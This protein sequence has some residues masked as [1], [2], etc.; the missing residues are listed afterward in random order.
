M[1]TKQKNY[2]LTLGIIIIF[3]ASLYG[4]DYFLIQT[5]K[6]ASRA[7]DTASQALANL[8]EKKSLLQNQE[9]DLKNREGHLALLDSVLIAKKE[10]EQV[11]SFKKIEE[12]ADQSG[13]MMDTPSILGVSKPA[14]GAERERSSDK[15]A[16][17]QDEE[18]LVL[19]MQVTGNFANILSFLNGLT[20]LP[21]YMNLEKIQLTKT[22]PQSGGIRGVLQ[23]RIFT[24]N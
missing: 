2:I 1:S 5:I 20:S 23:I 6:E 24:S 11:E 22:A 21:F 15:P 13:V 18:S 16:G 17:G 10:K 3:F 7:Y 9:Q 19:Q 8:D 14:E 4:L 12:L